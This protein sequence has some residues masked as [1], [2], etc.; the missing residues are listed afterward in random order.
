MKKIWQY[1]KS[2]KS[3]RR[4]L[5]IK[6]AKKGNT[7]HC[8][9]WR[10][11]PLLS[12]VGKILCRIIIDRIRSGVDDRLRKKQAGYRKGRE[13]TE[14]VFILRNIIEQVNE[15]QAFQ[16]TLSLIITDFD[17]LKDRLPKERSAFVR[18][19]RICHSK[20]IL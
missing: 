12:V 15:R 19:K 2:P 3:C 17:T 8:K 16:A 11:I 4:G 6:L 7:K 13:T 20:T 5:I 14:Q 18:F 1:Q 10:G 9:N